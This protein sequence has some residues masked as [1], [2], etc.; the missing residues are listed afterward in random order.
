MKFQA[1]VIPSQT[2]KFA[3]LLKLFTYWSLC[4]K[5]Q[6]CHPASQK[7]NESLIKSLHF[8]KHAMPHSGYVRYMANQLSEV[9]PFNY[10]DVSCMP[11]GGSGDGEPCNTQGAESTWS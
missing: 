9:W 11:Q 5:T 7:S 3:S 1:T 2:Q 8:A 6:I 10:E 4:V